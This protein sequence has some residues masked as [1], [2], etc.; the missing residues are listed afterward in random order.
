MTMVVERLD[1]WQV[2]TQGLGELLTTEASAS[3]LDLRMFGQP[4]DYEPA[5]LRSWLEGLARAADEAAPTALPDDPVPPTLRGAL[6]GL[7]FSHA[8]LWSR[9]TGSICSVAL[10]SGPDRIA[11][12]WVGEASVAVYPQDPAGSSEWVNI[13][14]ALGREARAWCGPADREARVELLFSFQLGESPARLEARWIPPSSQAAPAAPASTQ[15][16]EDNPSAGVARWL[17]QHVQWQ[18]ES[19][20][21]EAAEPATAPDLATELLGAGSA[22]EE[23]IDIAPAVEPPEIGVTPEAP[24]AA[25]PVML[26]QDLLQPVAA[27]AEAESIATPMVPVVERRAPP[28][29]PEWPAPSPDLEERAPL[30]WKRYA[31]VAA[32]IAGLFGIGWILGAVQSPE[33]PAETRR[34]SGFV[35]FLRGI[36]LAPPRFEITVASRPP[37]AWIAVDGKE[38]AVRAPARLELA[39]GT[40]RLGLSFPEVGGVVRTV[41]G[42]KNDQLAVSEPLWGSLD[43]AAADPTVPVS[44]ALDG[45]PLGLVPTRL[46]SLAPGPH[47]LRF[48]GSGM[49]SWGSTIELK[50][51]ERRE[52]LAYPLQSPATGLIQVRATMSGS[53]GAQ[54]L[55]GA[56]VWIDAEPRGITPLTLELPRGPHSV[57]VSYQQADAPVQVIDLPGGNQRFATFEL[58]L[59]SEFP[60]LLVRAPASIGVDE[61]ALISATLS[62]VE[63]SDVREMWLHVREPENRWRRY[64][65]TLMNAQGS[66]VGAAP[67]PVALLGPQGRTTYYVSAVTGQ[68]DEYFTEMQTAR[69]AGRR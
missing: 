49:A 67:F 6:G 2:S 22:I 24:S 42:E 11:F 3:G 7:L 69:A 28:R 19:A 65:M 50:V 37:G 29:R 52:V 34:S 16:A 62:D 10:V 61:P 30:P 47:E 66:A 38:L 57:R 4:S 59:R 68:G 63:A 26:P 12:G 17:A 18:A 25:E 9:E 46:D 31:A 48:S 39:P 36:G 44:V 56:R 41:V 40:H 13:R 8:E 5:E 21:G 64:P 35:R 15:S 33:G 45:Q 27:A 43:V 32:V 14:D 23:M 58:G 51:G 55:Q 20:T 1:R 60:T 54:P 53:D